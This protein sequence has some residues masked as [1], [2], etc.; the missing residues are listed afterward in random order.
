MIAAYYPP[1]GYN[2]GSRGI[3]G[4]DAS[5]SDSFSCVSNLSSELGHYPSV[6]E[7]VGRKDVAVGA[8][9]VGMIVAVM[10]VL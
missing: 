4:F 10:L 3:C 9:V 7:G 8:A 1:A 6:G 5:T 2:N